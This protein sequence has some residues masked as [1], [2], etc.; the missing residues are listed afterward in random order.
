MNNPLTTL[1]LTIGGFFGLLAALMAYLITYGEYVHHY[2]GKKEPREL[3]L[4]AAV[5]TFIFFFLLTLVGGYIIV[6]YIE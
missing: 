6:K 2:Q 4:E 1:C 5:F 3:A